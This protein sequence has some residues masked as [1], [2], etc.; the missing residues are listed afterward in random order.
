MRW[1]SSMHIQIASSPIYGFN[2]NGLVMLIQTK[3]NPYSIESKNCLKRNKNCHEIHGLFVP[4][5]LRIGHKLINKYTFKRYFINSTHRTNRM[6]SAWVCAPDSNIKSHITWFPADFLDKL[7]Q[8]LL[9]LIGIIISPCIF[10]ISHSVLL[11]DVP[12]I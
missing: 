9:V 5:K 12:T 10:P 6:E 1:K 8:N 11:K 3:R 2:S 4:E 7:H